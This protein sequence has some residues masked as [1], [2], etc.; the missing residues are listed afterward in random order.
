M[1][2]LRAAN[3]TNR[4]KRLTVGLLISLALG[5]ALLTQSG[6]QAAAQ[7]SI[8]FPSLS[9]GSRGTNVEA[10]QN[11][12]LHHGYSVVAD[13]EFDSQTKSGVERFQRANRIGNDGEVGPVTWRALTDVGNDYTPEVTT[14]VSLLL[15]SLIHI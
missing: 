11:L 9:L 15:L 6:G 2:D 3:S 7:S 8:Q 12:L 10:A 1:A 5:I 13:G 14:A 4:R